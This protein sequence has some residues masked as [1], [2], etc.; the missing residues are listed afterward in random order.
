M[1]FHMTFMVTMVIRGVSPHLYMSGN[2]ESYILGYIIIA[3]AEISTQVCLISK[4]PFILFHHPA[5]LSY[6]VFGK[7]VMPWGRPSF[8]VIKHPV[9][10]LEDHRLLPTERWHGVRND[11]VGA[12]VWPLATP[13]TS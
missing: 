4:S 2:M 6:M 8:H 13:F 3:G 9:D 10:C 7:K 12:R 11:A 5:F 1:L